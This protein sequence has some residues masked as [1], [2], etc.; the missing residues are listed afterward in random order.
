MFACAVCLLVTE[1]YLT[2]TS[3][4]PGT[5]QVGGPQT[6][7]SRSLTELERT[8]VNRVF[9]SSTSRP[10]RYLKI[11]NIFNFF[12]KATKNHLSV[13]FI[14]IFYIGHKNAQAC[15]RNVIKILTI[16]YDLLCSGIYGFPDGT[17]K[18]NGGTGINLTHNM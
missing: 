17:I 3:A 15:R 11:K 13:C 4:P 14:E 9:C 18:L 2:A 1:I 6:H 8:L 7:G 16:N 5:T 10:F 12:V